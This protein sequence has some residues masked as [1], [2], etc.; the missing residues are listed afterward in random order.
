MSMTVSIGVWSV[1]VIGA[2]SK[3]LLSFKGAGP[4]VW[5]QEEGGTVVKITSDCPLIPSNVL[6]ALAETAQQ[7]IIPVIILDTK[8]QNQLNKLI[9][10]LL[11]NSYCKKTNKNF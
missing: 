8:R 1:I 3:I 10:F 9:I 7:I 11:P 5:Q 4:K 6:L 2:M